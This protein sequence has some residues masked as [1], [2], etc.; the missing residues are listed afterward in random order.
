MIADGTRA[1][2][3]TPPPFPLRKS[4]ALPFA[5][6]LSITIAPLFTKLT[7]PPAFEL[8]TSSP[9]PFTVTPAF[10]TADVAVQNLVAHGRL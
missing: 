8:D 5:P 7:A 9:K 1:R 10:T 6:A 2:I 4:A 3:V